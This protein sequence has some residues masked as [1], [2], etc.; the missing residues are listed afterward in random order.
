MPELKR[1]AASAEQ[2]RR[3]VREQGVYAI[4]DV[5][6]DPG[7]AAKMQSLPQGQA[8]SLFAGSPF[9]S[10][11]AVAPYL[12]RLDEPLGDW[13]YE[14]LWKKPW[15]ILVFS[16]TPLEQLFYHFRRFV[17]ARLPDGAPSFLRFYDPRILPAFLASPEALHFGFWSGIKSFGWSEGEAATFMQWPGG[18]PTA[19][20]PPQQEISLSQGLMH[21]FEKVQL[22]DFLERCRAYIELAGG[23]LPEGNEAVLHS[24]LRYG[25]SV[26]IEQEIDALRFILLVLGW[27]EMRSLPVVREILNYPEVKGSD[28][29][30]LLCEL[31]AFGGFSPSPM[32]ALGLDKEAN[33]KAMAR[34]IAQHSKDEQF[35]KTHPGGAL[36]IGPA[37][38]RW[39][40]EWIKIYCALVAER[41]KVTEIA[42][43]TASI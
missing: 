34:F 27:K 9:E 13:V 25:I 37:D 32:E 29:V 39:R 19:T 6:G 14:E 18:A 36:T 26:G 31:A 10:Y 33:Q 2:Y 42:V 35:L 16:P 20:A 15:G 23:K 21:A 12:A 7:V 17:Q 1:I 5:A 40:K 4:F 24:I 41:A 43:G 38:T 8:V 28:K 3:L 22:K 11:T 30:D